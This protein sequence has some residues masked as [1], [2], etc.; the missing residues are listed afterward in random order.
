M[1]YTRASASD[2]DDWETIHGNRGWGS[3]SLVPLLQMAETYQEEDTNGT[4]GAVG[5]I[6]ASFAPDLVQVGS[7]FLDAARGYDKER[8]FTD[9]INGFYEC[10]KYGVSLSGP[11]FRV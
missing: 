11:S 3:D 6:K 9:D 7:D 2:Y 5:P 1:V 4:H 10:N 8:G